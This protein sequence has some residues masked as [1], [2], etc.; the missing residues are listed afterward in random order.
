MKMI[1]S[2]FLILFVS[3]LSSSLAWAQCASPTGTA[4]TI[5]WISASSKV[6]WCD[7]TNWKDTTGTTGSSCSGTT[8]GTISYASATLSYCNG[9]NWISMKGASAGSCTGTTAGTFTYNSG[10]SK[11]RFCDGTNWYNMEASLNCTAPWGA[12]VN[13]GS[14]VTAYLVSQFCWDYGDPLNSC[15]QA[16]NYESRTCTNGVLS[17]YMSN[18]SCIVTCYGC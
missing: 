12:T 8:A 16:G 11:Y 13:N 5:R 4:G 18:Q 2:A 3:C 10:A 9:T 1:Q 14:S 7:G 15:T 17:G 6:M